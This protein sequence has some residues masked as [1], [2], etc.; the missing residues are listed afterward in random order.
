MKT[1]L[2][3]L[4][5]SIGLTLAGCGGSQDSA[6]G[7]GSS[8]KQLFR[9]VKASAPYGGSATAVPGTLHA[10]NYD[11]GGQGVGYNVT[12]INGTANNYRADGV[13][14][15][16]TSA[17]GGGDDLG[18]T[19][20]GQWFNYSINV[21]TA[22][23]YTVSF[24]VA[25]PGAVTDAFH[26]SNSAGTNLSGA[27][28][29]PATGGWQT[30]TTVTATVTL[31]AGQQI[32]TLNQDNGGW[33]IDEATFALVNSTPTEAPY[34][35]TPAA[36][37]GTVHA[38]NYDTGGQG[39]G[40]NVASTNGTANS[41]RADGID[42]E[43]TSA[44]GGG[45]DLGW[46]AAGQWFR[47]TV[48]VATAGTYTVSFE[49]TAPSAVAGAFHL[50]NSSGTNL[51]GPVAVPAT[52][53]W[54]SWTTVTAT[55]T[56]PA[57]RQVLTL[58]EDNGGWNIDLVTFSQ[59]NAIS[60]L[61]YG[62]VGDGATDNQSALQNAFNAAQA[63]GKPVSIPAGVFNHSGVLSANGIAIQGAGF[64]T[65]LQATNPN[66][67]A[68]ELQGNAPSISN[69]KTEV[70]APNRSN[71]PQTAAIWILNATNAS[72]KNVILQGAGSNGV[73]L[74]GATYATISN[75]LVLGTNADGIAATNGASHN[76]IANN[77][78]YQSADDAY[79]DDSYVGEPQD[80]GNQFTGNVAYHIPYGRGFA[81]AGSTGG[82]FNGN[83]ING[84]T[85]IGI[86]AETDT[87]SN[88]QVTSNYTIENNVVLNANTTVASNYTTFNGNPVGG[89][90]ISGNGMVVSNNQTTGSMP[91]LSTVLGWDPTSY[92]V[93]RY[94]F[95]PTYVPGTG[96][97]S[98][99]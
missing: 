96:P 57:G 45:N 6:S 90:L 5:A 78:V 47:Y 71:Q 40:Y 91:T 87:S 24:V 97:G 44:A 62:A 51:S 20:T 59:S 81:A 42:L 31:P 37:P 17:A 98:S 70:V 85:W 23:T 74:D 7:D 83:T 14:L 86:Y 72:V 73:R 32:L 28:N 95:N 69:L 77:L 41:Y 29:V 12:S 21:A 4:F 64:S 58:S 16:T 13:D 25:A 1:N 35:G 30:W 43:A 61:S 22:G 48:N 93:D 49:V 11:T 65:I 67:G 56:L 66:E 89:W 9:S 18:W 63:Q 52:G 94:S 8:Q 2:L 84:T 34:G 75:N 10:E 27:I 99:N 50:A 38:E 68:I 92:M 36:I 53:G 46:T 88:T 19:A 54:Q 82:V 26:V 3:F 55:V 33:N 76:T 60:V 79:S 15:E 80:V 39:T